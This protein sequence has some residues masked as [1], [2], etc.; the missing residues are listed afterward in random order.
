M[1]PARRRESQPTLS[2]DTDEGG[3]IINIHHYRPF[4]SF[5]PA[6]ETINVTLNIN[7]R[8]Y[9]LI[10]VFCNTTCISLS[11]SLFLCARCFI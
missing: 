3:T 4:S 10:T 8:I 9:V 1:P 7:T 5:Q 11:L 6:N 2:P